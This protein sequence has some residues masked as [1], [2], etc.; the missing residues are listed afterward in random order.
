MALSIQQYDIMFIFWVIMIAKRK[1][2]SEK[3]FNSCMS[4][5]KKFDY[6]V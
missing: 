6:F 1:K 5:E 3:R 4:R 2:E